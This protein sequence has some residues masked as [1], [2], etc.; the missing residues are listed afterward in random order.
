LE[1]PTPLEIEIMFDG[2]AI[3]RAAVLLSNAG[4]I[5]DAASKLKSKASLASATK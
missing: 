1:I 2:R 3:V 5:L 4:R